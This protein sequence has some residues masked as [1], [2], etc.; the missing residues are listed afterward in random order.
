M[1]D[2]TIKLRKR[3]P[4]EVQFIMANKI[5]TLQNENKRLREALKF[6]ADRKNWE[7]G[8]PAPTTMLNDAGEIARQALKE[9]K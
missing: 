3:E 2:N 6:Y 8:M 1:N 7:E 4:A 5:G 9:M